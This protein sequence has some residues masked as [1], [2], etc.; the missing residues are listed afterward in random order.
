VPAS[1]LRFEHRGWSAAHELC[2]KR[3]CKELGVGCEARAELDFLLVHRAGGRSKPLRFSESKAGG[4]GRVGEGACEGVFGTFVV[5]LPSD[6]KGGSLAVR[7]GGER[8]VFASGSPST[9]SGEPRLPRVAAL[10]ASASRR[11]SW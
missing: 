3:V 2:V 7:H 11:W 4:A 5:I 9:A 1:K 6:L 8:P 10:Y